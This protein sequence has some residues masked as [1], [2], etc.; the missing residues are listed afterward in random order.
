MILNI[1]MAASQHT[2]QL[3]CDNN[4]SIAMSTTFEDKASYAARF[5]VFN[6][7]PNHRLVAPFNTPGGHTSGLSRQAQLAWHLR[8]PESGFV[9]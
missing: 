2:L 7:F 4:R 5:I 3:S 1:L 8:I 6:T 9:K